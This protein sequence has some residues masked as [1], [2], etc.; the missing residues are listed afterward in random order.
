MSKLLIGNDC[1]EDLVGSFGDRA[2]DWSSQ[3]VAWFMEDGDVFLSPVP[4]DP[5]FLRYVAHHTGTDHSS[6]RVVVA[7]PAPDDNRLTRARLR[8]ERLLHELRAAV[9]AAGVDEVLP[10]WPNAEV[11]RLARTLGLASGLPGI[12]FLE[13]D[14]EFVA[15]SK[16]FF[17]TLAA[18]AGV[19]I[20]RGHVAATLDALVE[21]LH[22]LLDEGL[23]VMLKRDL[24]GGGLGNE[25][26]T[27]HRD[28]IAQ[29]AQA[30]VHL[31]GSDELRRYAERRWDWLSNGGRQHVV[32]ERLHSP[33]RTVF[34]EFSVTGAE[35]VPEGTGELLFPPIGAGQG[36][37]DQTGS[38]VLPVR[39]LGPDAERQLRDGGLALA[40]ALQVIGYRGNISADAIVTTDDEVLFTE[41][42]CRLTSST[43]VWASI[44][45]RIVGREYIDDRVLVDR[46]GWHVPSFDAA[47]EA[48]AAAGIAYDHDRRRGVLLSTAMNPRK[49]KIM[50]CMVVEDYSEVEEIEAKLLQL[51]DQP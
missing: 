26:V 49:K 22:E 20:A 37:G 29:G 32:V 19:P 43:H 2:A 15:N 25:V 48:L 27:R 41:V 34:H 9:R 21:Q 47:A 1:S 51:F 40:R 35:L 24:L 23:D 11:A 28:T 44:G 6:L 45:N 8:D 36:R 30:V 46:V 7:G 10:L 12:G 17:R 14:G 5:S 38:E 31:R 13:Q 39:G 4:P 33:V 18:G 3:R 16:A 50:Y 42:N